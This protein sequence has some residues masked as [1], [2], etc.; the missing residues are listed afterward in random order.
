[1]FSCSTQLSIKFIMLITFKMPTFVC[2]LTVMSMIITTSEHL[3]AINVFIFKHFQFY[4]HFQFHAQL[5]L[6]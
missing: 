3:K 6:A 5:S 2:I 1:M 4:E